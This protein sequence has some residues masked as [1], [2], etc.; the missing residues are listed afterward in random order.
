MLVIIIACCAH[1]FRERRWWVKPWLNKSRGN[2]NIINEFIKEND[3]DSYTNFLRMKEDTF[4]KLLNK[5]KRR[6]SKRSY[7]REC[8]SAKDK[9]IITLRYLATGESYRSLMYSFRISE[10]TISL[11]IPQVCRVIYE[12]LRDEYLKVRHNFIRIVHH[13]TELHWYV[14]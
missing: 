9:L 11:F 4:L 7:R 3:W 1:L 6:I 2:R 8:V 10:S 5:I 12:E 13:S 14:F